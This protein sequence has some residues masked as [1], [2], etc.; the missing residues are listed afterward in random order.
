M[1]QI[2]GILPLF[3]RQAGKDGPKIYLYV[4]MGLVFFFYMAKLPFHVESPSL[5]VLPENI[6]NSHFKIKCQTLL[7]FVVVVIPLFL[8][9]H[10]FGFFSKGKN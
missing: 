4:S 6:K 5:F 10:C 2:G 8:S 3:N 7:F 1:V 9:S